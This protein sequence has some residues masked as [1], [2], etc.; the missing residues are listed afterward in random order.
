M[1]V[2][3]AEPFQIIYSLYSHQYLGPLFESF[4]IQLDEKGEL[5]FRH[6]NI[7]HKNAEEFASGLDDIDYELI[8]LMDSIQQDVILKKF[9]N[10]KITPADFFLKV[11]DKEKGDKKGFS[12]EGL[13]FW[14]ARICFAAFASDS[15]LPS[16]PHD[17]PLRSWR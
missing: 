15:W 13:R 11:Y 9:Y 6:Q 4:A 14:C 17:G 7:S 16:W 3:T 12:F 1:K 8:R 2:S 5:T 10:K